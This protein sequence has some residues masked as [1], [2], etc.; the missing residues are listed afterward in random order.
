MINFLIRHVIKPMLTYVPRT[1]GMCDKVV[2]ISPGFFIIIPDRFKTKN[3]CSK[4][5]EREPLLVCN[6][7]ACLNDARNV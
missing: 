3:M 1:Q 2:G 7:P 5:V 6:V 4:T